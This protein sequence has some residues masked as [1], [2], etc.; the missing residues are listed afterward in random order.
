MACVTFLLPSHTPSSEDLSPFLEGG[1]CLGFKEL[2]TAE[3]KSPRNGAARKNHTH[4][5][6]QRMLIYYDVDS[7]MQIFRELSFFRPQNNT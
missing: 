3:D 6:F 5:R 2:I 4:K 1:R 7:T